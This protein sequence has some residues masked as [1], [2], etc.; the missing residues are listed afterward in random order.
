[1]AQFFTNRILG[2]MLKHLNGFNVY[3]LVIPDT[4]QFNYAKGNADVVTGTQSMVRG[5]CPSGLASE[6][7]TKTL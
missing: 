2:Y 5:P 4:H 7:S 6:E 1:M 3:S